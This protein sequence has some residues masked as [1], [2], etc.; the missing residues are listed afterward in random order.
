MREGGR[1]G[2]EGRES[3]HHYPDS[4]HT[5]TLWEELKCSRADLC[6]GQVQLSQVLQLVIEKQSQALIRHLHV[7]HLHHLQLLTT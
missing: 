1:E 7:G 5:P 4:T 2:R 3:P 6:I